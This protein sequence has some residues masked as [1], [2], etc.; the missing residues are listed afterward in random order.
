M[1]VLD[2]PRRGH[3]GIVRLTDD[4]ARLIPI[5]RKQKEMQIPK[6]EQIVVVAP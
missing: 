1:K 6:G 3:I 5:D 4:G 2:K